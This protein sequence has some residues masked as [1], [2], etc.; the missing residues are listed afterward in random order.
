MEDFT[1]GS[2]TFSQEVITTCGPLI[3]IFFIMIILHDK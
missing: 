1:D 2:I 3:I